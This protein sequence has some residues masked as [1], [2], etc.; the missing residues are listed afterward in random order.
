MNEQ[1]PAPAEKKSSAGQDFIKKIGP[2]GCALFLALFILTTVLCFTA[3]SNPIKGYEP[4]QSR[5]YY[6]ANPDVL[7]AELEQTVFPQLPYDMTAGMVGDQVTV[8]IA[9]DDLVM[10]RAALLQLFGHDLLAFEEK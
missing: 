8:R 9:A 2:W 6:A 1:T 10:G 4:P 7:I 3:G 5:D